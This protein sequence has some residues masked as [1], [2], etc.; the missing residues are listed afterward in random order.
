M[1]E[2]YKRICLS[3]Q[4]GYWQVDFKEKRVRVDK[5]LQEQLRLDKAEMSI[6]DFLQP[7]VSVEKDVLVQALNQ[8]PE[9]DSFEKY[10]GMRIGEEHCMLEV[11]L[12]L[13]KRNGGQI[14]SAEGY[15]RIIARHFVSHGITRTLNPNELYLSPTNAKPTDALSAKELYARL[16]MACQAALVYPFSWS[17]TERMFEFS[18][19][20]ENKIIR[21]RMSLAEFMGLIHEDDRAAADPDLMIFT[22]NSGAH[23][24]IQFRSRYF[25]EERWFEMSGEV[26]EFQD[27]HT[28]LKAIGALHDITNHM[29]AQHQQEE[30][31][32]RL[33]EA[34]QK[35]ERAVADRNLALN[36]LNAALVYIN[37]DF[38]VQWSSM[39]TMK[40]VLGNGAYATG[41]TCYKSTFGRDT[42][43]PDCPVMHVFQTGEFETYRI[44]RNGET[45][46]VMCNP[47]FNDKNKLIGGVLKLETITERVKQEERISELNRLM[48]AILNN[49]PVFLYVKDPNDNFKYL[50]WNKALADSTRF[51]TSQVVGRTDMDIYNAK[52]A[53][54][55]REN[56][57]KLLQSK[58]KMYFIE[59]FKNIS[60]ELKIASSLKTLIP[61]SEGKLPWILGI[62]WDIT[63]LKK[64]EKELTLAKEKAEESNRLKSAFLANMSHEIRTPLNAIVGF[65]D[66]LSETE[67]ISEKMEY[68]EIIKNNNELLLQLI[69]DI[70]DLSKIEAQTI[71]FVYEMVD[72]HELTTQI[73][74]AGKLRKEAK[75]PVL[76][77]RFESDCHIYTDKNRINQVI[78]NF[79]TNALKFTS[80]GCVKVGY[81]TTDNEMVRFYVRDTGT[82]IAI[83][84]LDVV[85]DRFVKLD[86]FKQ[87]T[88]L[89]LSI[90]KSIIEELGGSIGVESELGK[91]SCFWFTLPH[92][93]V[94]DQEYDKNKNKQ[95]KRVVTK[96]H[97]KNQEENKPVILVAEDIDS[98]YKLVDKFL[99]SSYNLIR[100]YN[101]KEAVELYN[102]LKPDIILMD[103]HMPEM[104][105]LQATREIRQKDQQIPIIA[106]SAYSYNANEKRAEQS[107]CDE[108][109]PKPVTAKKLRE[110]IDSYVQFTYGGAW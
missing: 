64:K 40:K 104:D 6:D 103:L 22:K 79:I 28:P 74:A 83:D 56:D 17:F 72:L 35:I 110:R 11:V 87:G 93:D 12:N 94:E 68:I 97:V 41:K 14:I 80:K 39:K 92:N 45:L 52:D 65:S 101:G 91:G 100:A 26:F 31:T 21:N 25:K 86:T 19:F 102:K 84:K 90:C 36:N 109:I 95:F 47:I 50:Y 89:G 8:F 16:S 81:H 63:E 13:P 78:S 7:I 106:F 59:E 20:G 2:N 44:Q 37:Q 49:I 24:K 85:F 70:L 69:S 48:D 38:V 108:F 1:E 67:D 73:V 61:T 18:T 5:Y 10:V 15:I 3:L 71:D 27:D 66:L 57:I 29:K 53:E 98:N 46:E 60:G 75:V 9:E 99:E 82:G 54:L 42:P 30:A 96:L 33:L 51:S 55:F 34:Q 107:G 88:G 23:F 76:L 43:C 4:M 105:G 58:S 77:D 62:S 32:K